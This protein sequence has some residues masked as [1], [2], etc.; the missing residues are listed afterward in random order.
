[1]NPLAEEL[2]RIIHASAPYLLEM[3]SATG[4]R[5]FFPSKG[6][7]SQSAEAKQLARKYNAT[8]GVAL[9]NGEA[10]YLPSVME[11]LPGISP[12]D[13]LLYAPSYGSMELRKAW[14]QLTLHDNPD[15]EGKPF[16]LP[17]VTGGLSHGLSLIADLCVDE[18]DLLVY[19]DKNWGNYA[20]NF[21]LRRGA[22]PRLFPLF[23]N[24]GFNTAGLRQV[25]ATAFAEGRRKAIV[26]L[27]FPNNPTGY[28]PTEA[29]CAAIASALKEYA[30]QGMNL[31]VIVD[32]A[33]YGLFFEPQVARQSLFTK[34]AGLH[35]RILAFKADAATKEVYVWGLR[36]GFVSFSIGG[37]KEEDPVFQAVNDK[38]GGLM[39]AVVSNCSALS[40]HLVTKALQN[41]QFY[42]ERAAN[43][44]IIRQRAA[45]AHE[46][47]QNPKFAQAWEPYP[48]N[49]GYF[50]SVKV[51][52]VSAADLR[53]H[54]LKKYGVGTI[55]INDTDLRFAFSSVELEQIPGLYEDAYR[56]WQ[57]LT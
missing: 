32:D 48:F 16:S 6:I 13:A 30:D 52:H 36:V 35:P 33:Y 40:Q 56:A 2:N 1:M 4:R 26:L 45:K 49:S 28:S 3:L 22:E 15:L 5:F 8:I 50:M 57:D 44:E 27:N 11:Q 37:V 17:V 47:L 34:L 53:I 38:M 41:P 23:A 31:V 14:R 10:M 55:A 46:V 43:V 24:G 29:E 39:R 42:A 20:L 21:V 12:N 9:R 51:K 19:P 18:G 25:L 54:L 7:L